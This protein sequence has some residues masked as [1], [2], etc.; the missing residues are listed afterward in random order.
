MTVR[1]HM[2][3]VDRPTMP[4]A[5][6]QPLADVF[7]LTTSAVAREARVPESRVVTPPIAAS[8]RT[9]AM[10]TAA[11]C[12]ASTPFPSCRIGP[13]ASEATPGLARL[14]EP[15]AREVA[16]ASARKADVR[17][18]DAYGHGDDAGE[19]QREEEAAGCSTALTTAAP[20]RAHVS[21]CPARPP[22]R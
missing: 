19:A 16:D 17:A 4:S 12:A 5:S 14:V 22:R 10:G 11:S 13:R 7:T 1:T 15:I 18:G 9:P 6:S 20:S 2:A 3:N 8:C 21:C